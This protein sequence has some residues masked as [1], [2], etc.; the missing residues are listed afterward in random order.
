[1]NQSLTLAAFG[2]CTLVAVVATIAQHVHMGHAL[3]VLLG[4]W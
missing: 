4:A 2:L 3:S 1:V